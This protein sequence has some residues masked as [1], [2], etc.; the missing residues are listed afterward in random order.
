MSTLRINSSKYQA[1]Q[2][3]EVAVSRPLAGQ[4]QGQLVS[5]I[6]IAKVCKEWRYE[7]M[8]LAGNIAW[9]DESW[10]RPSLGN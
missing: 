5:I 8:N 1:G 4:L 6:Q 3:V 9:M 2:I 10:L 7:V